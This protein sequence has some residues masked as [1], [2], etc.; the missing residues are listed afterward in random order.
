MV[1]RLVQGTF[2]KSR[3]AGECAWQTIVLTPMGNSNFHSIG[4]VY[5]LCKTVME[6][7]NRRLT[8]VIKFHNMLHGFQANR[9]TR[10]ASLKAKLIQQI[11]ARMEEVMYDIFFD[12]NK[13]YDALDCDCCL[14]TLA[15]YAVVPWVIRLL[16]W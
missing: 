11:K 3:L 14:D 12:I 7:L 4:L 16:C 1:V 13:S 10:T 8:A 15:A 5:V 9:G 2:C 6:I